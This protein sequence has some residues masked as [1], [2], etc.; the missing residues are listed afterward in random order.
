MKK[1]E[2]LP[3]KEE[4]NG[5]NLAQL[6]VDK[7]DIPMLVHALMIGVTTIRMCGG[8]KAAPRMYHYQ[9]VLEGMVPPGWKH[10]NREEDISNIVF[11]M[12]ESATW[13]IVHEKRWKK[14]TDGSVKIT[15]GDKSWDVWRLKDEEFKELVDF[16]KSIAPMSCELEEIK[17]ETEYNW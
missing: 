15:V 3:V 2:P 13:K 12:H 4:G 14:D 17:T 10:I 5:S 6:T 1:L 11:A 16:L 9:K 8:G 7:G